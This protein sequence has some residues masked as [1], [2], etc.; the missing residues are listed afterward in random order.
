M[1]VISK[2]LLIFS[3]FFLNIL[4]LCFPI[5]TSFAKENVKKDILDLYEFEE[6]TIKA[7][8]HEPDVLFIL[9]KPEIIIQPFE[10][11]I[12]FTEKIDDV[13]IEDMLF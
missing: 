3:V 2:N 12:D 1:K 13:L 11:E 7:K 10:S 6:L 9:D 8:I 4:L 5:E